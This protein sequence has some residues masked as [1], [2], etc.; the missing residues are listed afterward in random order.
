MYAHHAEL[1]SPQTEDRYKTLSNRMGTMVHLI[2]PH[3][4]TEVDM[5]AQLPRNGSPRLVPWLEVFAKDAYTN[6]FLIAQ[7]TVTSSSPTSWR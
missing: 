7:F 2:G 6:F 3:T 1:S 5:T 4:P